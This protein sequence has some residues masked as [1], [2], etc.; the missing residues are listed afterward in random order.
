MSA[1]V[2][3]SFVM[4]LRRTIFRPKDDHLHSLE[5]NLNTGLA[6]HASRETVS[7]ELTGVVDDEVRF[8][9]VP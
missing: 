8:A 1:T 6:S 7:R 2:L 3:V 9:K 5:V 4:G